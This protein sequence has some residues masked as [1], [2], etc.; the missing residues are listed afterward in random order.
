MNLGVLEILIT[1]III[2][3]PVIVFIR[4][5]QRNKNRTK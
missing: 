3:Y 4:K 5:K 2:G 1:I